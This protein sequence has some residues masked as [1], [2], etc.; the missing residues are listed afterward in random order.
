MNTNGQ[1]SV[2]DAGR[3]GFTLVEVLMA[4]GILVMVAAAA[5]GSFV[6]AGRQSI[7]CA[8]VGWSQN[9]AMRSS[10]RIEACI[11]NASEIVG[12][13]TN[14]GT[15]LEVRFPDRTT[16]RFTYQNALRDQRDGR[17]VLRRGSST[18]VLVARGLTEIMTNTGFTTPIFIRTRDNAVRVAYRVSEP[19]QS[20]AQAADDEPYAACVR[21]AVCL[22]NTAE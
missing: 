20:G 21:F 2:R 13:D 8:K 17:L 9:E 7:L 6:W 3:S 4:S 19:R 5:G 12:I 22:R 10:N 16:A 15:W 1:A 18:E 11:R 14:R